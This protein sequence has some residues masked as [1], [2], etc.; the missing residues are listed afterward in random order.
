MQKSLFTPLSGSIAQERALEVIAN[1][2][3]NVNTVGFKGEKVTF[4][5]LNPEPKKRYTEPLPNANYKISF[6]DLMPLVGNEVA[7]VGV[8][9]VRLDSSQGS[10]IK[11]GNPLDLMLEGK[12]FFEVQTPNG[13][14]FTRSGD[15]SISPD[16]VLAHKSGHAIMGT[17]GTIAL[18]QGAFEVNTLGEVYQNNKFIDKLK[19]HEFAIQEDLEKIGENLF[20]YGGSEGTA[21]LSSTTQVRQ[22]FLEGSNVNAIEN[23]TSMIKAH[24][25][26]EA[27]QKAVK[28]YDKMMERSHQDLGQ[29]RA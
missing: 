23:L 1:N 4:K 20:F 22:G 15:F 12:G 7:Y 26:Y 18:G 3:A 17:R 21:K 27:Y 10:A 9:G 24:R 11:T 16:G 5:L 29:V 25:S 19:I 14:R 28:N 13:T 8:A 6:Q 2:L